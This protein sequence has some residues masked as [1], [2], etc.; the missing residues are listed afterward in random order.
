M[1]RSLVVVL[2]LALLPD[3]PAAL[4]APEPR[5]SI[6]REA[7]KAV[8]MK[9]ARLIRACYESALRRRPDLE[10]RLSVRFTIAASGSV[11]S[12]EVVQSTLKDREL[13]ECVLG[14]VRRMV[15]PPHPEP[16]VVIVYPFVF[17]NPSSK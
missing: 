12:A 3:S 10:G 5:T 1:I 17:S 7:V 2:A 13:E 9:H 15:F 8:I 6:D 16:P 11:T 4:S 14:V